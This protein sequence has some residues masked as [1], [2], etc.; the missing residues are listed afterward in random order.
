MDEVGIS[1]IIGRFTALPAEQTPAQALARLDA[2]DDALIV[3][4][5]ADEEG[6]ERPLAVL[7]RAELAE[8]TEPTELTGPV[9]PVEP[10]GEP[11]L[12][13]G[14]SGRLPPLISIDIGE[15]R[16]VD[17]ETLLTLVDTLARS[18]TTPGVLVEHDEE[19]LGVLARVD[20]AAIL[21]V[22]W[23]SQGEHRYGPGYGPVPDVPTRRYVCRKCAPPS[24]RLPRSTGGA[25]PNCRRIWFHGPMEPDGDDD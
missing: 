22:E 5:A 12:L 18:R 15:N 8:L 25:A 1:S 3:I 16:V 7:S 6:V 11:L 10:A 17:A 23:L 20:V 4:T 9:E 24:Y 13:S 14:L 19:P 2:T 21:P